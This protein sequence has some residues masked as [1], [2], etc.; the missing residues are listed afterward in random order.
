MDGREKSTRILRKNWRG[1]LERNF[2]L[3]MTIDV[4]QKSPDRREA[5]ERK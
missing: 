5:S 1:N 2:G 3:K 4:E